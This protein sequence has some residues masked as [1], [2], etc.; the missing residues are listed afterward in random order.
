MSFIPLAEVT[1]ML[2]EDAARLKVLCEKAAIELNH[3]ELIRLV[4]E[5]TALLDKNESKPCSTFKV[6]S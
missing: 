3:D 4:R 6:A 5:I 1:H 2:S